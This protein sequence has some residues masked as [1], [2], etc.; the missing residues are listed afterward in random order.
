MNRIAIIGT[1][2]SGK[3][4]LAC[5]ISRILHIPHFELDHLYWQENWQPLERELFRSKVRKSDQH[6]RWVID[7]N[8]S[9]VRDLIWKNADTIIWLDYPFHVVFLQA[10]ARSIRRIV[11][12]ERLFADNIETF[13]QTFFSKN[14]I[15]YWICTSHWDYKKTY[16][17]LIRNSKKQIIE[18]NSMRDKNNFLIALTDQKGTYPASL[19]RVVSSREGI[20]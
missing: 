6:E 17:R 2:C 7:G 10:L 15:L 11:N 14:S 8:F 5:N 16:T 4:T 1:S 13:S 3:S 18:L 20:R 9:M 19:H 12:R